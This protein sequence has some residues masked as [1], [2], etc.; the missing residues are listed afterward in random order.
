MNLHNCCA[1]Y[2]IPSYIERSRSGNGGHL[3][4]FF[5]DPIPVGQSR[6]LMFEL[7]RIA[8]IISHFEKEPSFDR[9]FPNQD[10]HSG[11]GFGN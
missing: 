2:G 5:E 3:W 4:V 7:L 9:L 11:K 10:Y 8:G 1:D 6:K